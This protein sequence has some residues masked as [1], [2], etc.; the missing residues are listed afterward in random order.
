MRPGTGLQA[1]WDWYTARSGGRQY[2]QIYLYD[3]PKHDS[4]DWS[5]GRSGRWFWGVHVIY[6]KHGVSGITVA[7][8]SGRAVCKPGYG[9]VS[10]S[11]LGPGST[12]ST[13]AF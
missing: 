8:A 13:L 12:L 11:K 1:T 7:V 6:A 9:P 2:H 10:L 4:E 3:I 5:I